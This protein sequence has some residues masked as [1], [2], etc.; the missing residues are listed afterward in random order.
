MDTSAID[1]RDRDAVANAI[2]STAQIVADSAAEVRK[3]LEPPLTSL[4]H[5]TDRRPDVATGEDKATRDAFLYPPAVYAALEEAALVP[6]SL[7]YTAA[8]EAIR[9]RGAASTLLEAWQQM[10]AD[11]GLASLAATKLGP[12]ASLA[13]KKVAPPLAVSSAV[14]SVEEAIRRTT[15]YAET[16]TAFLAVLEPSLRLVED[17][18]SRL[19]VWTAWGWAAIDILLALVEVAPLIAATA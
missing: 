9:A 11:V 1:G 6:G 8:S 7:A 14:L 3:E 10:N 13:A 12:L 18:P 17:D 16:K 19:G 5:L 2:V 4:K 15:W